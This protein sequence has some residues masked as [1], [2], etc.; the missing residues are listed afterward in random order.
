MVCYKGSLKELIHWV[1]VLFSSPHRFPSFWKQE[2]GDHTVWSFILSGCLW[3]T[4]N[5]CFSS[6]PEGK[7]SDH[8][9]PSQ[10][11]SGSRYLWQFLFI[12]LKKKNF[13]RTQEEQMWSRGSYPKMP[14][15]MSELFLEQTL[16]RILP[17]FP[18][19]DPQEVVLKW[20]WTLN[21]KLNS[22]STRLIHTSWLYMIHTLA[23]VC[24][25]SRT[26]GTIKLKKKNN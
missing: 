13:L 19:P 21:W 12:C 10:C 6:G 16:P 18:Q 5:F 25:T 2:L 17:E 9:R 20:G 7:L 22:V 24:G 1:L 23:L 14:T 26:G 4:H 8:Q 3:R 11:S 15:L